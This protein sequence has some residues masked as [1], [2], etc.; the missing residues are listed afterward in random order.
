MLVARKVALRRS[1]GAQVSVILMCALL[2]GLDVRDL[3][4]LTVQSPGCP[5]S[6]PQPPPPTVGSFGCGTHG[7]SGSPRYRTICIVIDL[8][9]CELDK[10]LP[11][12]DDVATSRELK[13]VVSA[14]HQPLKIRVKLR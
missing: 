6:L 14:T 4:W 5:P 10:E 12:L 11:A 9:T 3:V 2:A 13:Q 1:G 7:H 8:S